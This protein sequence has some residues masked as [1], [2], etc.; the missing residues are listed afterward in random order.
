MLYQIVFSVKVLMG[1]DDIYK[2]F[3]RALK[4]QEERH[5]AEKLLKESATESEISGQFIYFL[6]LLFSIYLKVLNQL[7]LASIK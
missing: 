2:V 5:I 7:C 4:E 1:P 3:I 6:L